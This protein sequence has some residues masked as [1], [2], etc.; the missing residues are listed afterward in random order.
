MLL[1]VD[2]GNTRTS[3]GLFEGKT[4]ERTISLSTI[5]ERTP[6]EYGALLRTLVGERLEGADVVLAAVVPVVEGALFE[7]FERYAHTR[8]RR[9][10]A[11][12]FPYLENRAD[13]PAEVGVD[14]LI[15]AFAGV[16]LHGA[17]L[18]I[19]DLGTA[20]TWDVVSPDGAYLGG[21]IAPGLELASRA[22]YTQTARLPR[23]RIEKPPA[24]LGRDTVR[25]MESG[26]YYGLVGAI[27]EV[28]QRIRRELG[29]SCPVIATGGHAALLAEECTVID[30]VEPHLTLHG[31]RLIAEEAE[32]P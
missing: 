12:H 2:V 23:V 15:N 10:T 3:L 21:A 25:A 9:V 17:P 30:R 7:A 14:R 4:L 32:V 11:S 31:L 1:C 16:R 27:T 28:S 26:L 24:A 29:Q 8:P 5:P 6:D 13:R 18:I 22:L 20:T 19:V